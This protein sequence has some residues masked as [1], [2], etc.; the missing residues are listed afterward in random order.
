M[1][2]DFQII[3]LPSLRVLKTIALLLTIL[4]GISV[5]AGT[6]VLTGTNSTV[7]L[8]DTNGSILSVEA[9]GSTIATG[10]EA[11]LWSVSF[12]DGTRLDAAAFVSG[13][14]INS[15]QWEQPPSGDMLVLTYSNAAITTTVTLSER[16][17][18]VDLS[19]QVQPASKTV[20]EF[21]LPERLRFAPADTQR[22]ITPSHSSDGVGTAFNGR[23]FESQPESAPAGWTTE[24]VGT[25]GYLSLYGG[26]LVFRPVDDPPV[27]IS[28]TSDGLT[29]LGADLANQWQGTS[30]IV[31]RPPGTGQA[32]V[33]LLSSTNG[34]F[35][36]GSQLG[37]AGWLLRLGGLVDETRA[38]LALDAVIA[39]IEHLAQTPG[40]RTKVAL[41][42]MK[43]GPASGGW[44]A[45]P[46]SDWR[47]RLK[48]S[49]ALAAAGIEVVE[50]SH[51]QAMLDA[52]T[53]TEYLAVLN[54]YGEWTPA[55]SGGGLSA[56]V[57]AIGDYVFAGGSWFE[58]GGHPFYSALV[59]TAYYS[60]DI[61]YPPAFADFLHLETVEGNASLYGVQPVP[62]DPWAGETN[63]AAL[64]VPGRLGWGADAQG[65][66]FER[67]FG[68]Y[69][70]PG[71]TWQSPI[72]RLA[73]GQA[74]TNSLQ[75][76]GQ[77]NGLDRTLSDKMDPDVLDKFKGSV[78][79]NL[80]GT[81]T[82]MTE[83]L[84][85]L[86]SPALVHFEQ[87]LRGGFDKEYPD[88]FPPNAWFGTP[89]EFTNFLGQCR[90]A[91]LLSMPYSNPTWWCDNPRG[92][93]FLAAGT[94]PLLIKL[95][96]SNSYENYSGNDGYTVCHWHPDVQAA[97]RA[98]RD[99]FITN[100]PVD[101][102]FE[103]Q[104]G[105][106]TWQYD[107]NAASPTPYAYAAGIA[108][109]A[110]EN[111]QSLPLSTENG[112]DRVINYEAQFSGMSWGLVPTENPPDWREFL[113]DRF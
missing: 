10:G 77:A 33:V 62:T 66:Y 54:P 15:F 102:L 67:A 17:D 100:Y 93:T 85:Q 112:W 71:Q 95:D 43:R 55:L 78:L 65:G 90:Q 39:A 50:L 47:D 11:G 89:S 91:G 105:A 4:P 5:W 2:T 34:A 41:L 74:V 61:D 113:R 13:S 9:G 72:V 31:N 44:A 80:D 27:P 22:L 45:V 111:S 35:F 36:S 7:V 73:L 96:G 23:F 57:T 52:L 110:A 49:A 92:P 94:D 86:P 75:A 83:H 58:V 68:T 81:A 79:V 26:S 42:A 6:L 82:Q 76:Y 29:W 46:V 64:F 20:L 88:H 63:A 28:F 99:E 103:D 87:Y 106:R 97:N 21:S 24:A 16:D 37:G 51:A 84:Y 3:K 104:V 101:I 109:Q 59:P 19:A 40:G 18:G 32:D 98:I 1:R 38:P 107:L 70:T 8:S 108:A 69:I 56:T 60:Q 14:P 53:G 25:G 12:E 48:N 30:A